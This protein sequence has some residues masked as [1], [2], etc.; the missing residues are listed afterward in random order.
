MLKLVILVLIGCS[1]CMPLSQP[2]T[3]DD[4]TLGILSPSLPSQ[5]PVIKTWHHDCS[6]TSGFEYTEIPTDYHWLDYGWANIQAKLESDGQSLLMPSVPNLPNPSPVPDYYGPVYAYT[7]PDV[8]PLSGLRNLSVQMELNNSDSTYVGFVRVGLFDA[9]DA[10]VLI[11]K[12]Q[13]REYYGTEGWIYW[14]Y[15]LR[16]QTIHRYFLKNEHSND[17]G[18]G[19]SLTQMEFVNATWSS[20]FDP[21]RGLIGSIPPLESLPTANVTFVP[22][23]EVETAH[24]IRYLVLMFGMYYPWRN[25]PLIP[26]RI[27]DIFLE[28]E[29]SGVI[30]TTPPLLTPQLDVLYVV[31][32]TGNVINWRCTDDNPYRYWLFDFEY[33]WF[34]LGHN[35]KEGLWTGSPYTI[36][37]DGLEVGNRTFLLILQDKA[38]FMVW[39]MVTVIVV[40]HPFVAFIITN[41]IIIVI[42]TIIVLGCIFI[43]ME[44]R[45]AALYRKERISL[46]QKQ[47]SSAVTSQY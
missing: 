23:E 35:M 37:V 6:N 19:Y 25:Q 17:Y 10:P 20:R 38:G 21:S 7:L 30:D 5:E 34:S 3:S 15:Y 41:P 9:S 24:D 47:G 1:L 27:H 29:T 28:Y 18:M 43:L 11:S 22:I 4:V 46:Y 12:I 33:P 32:Q 45:K 26:V 13:D 14:D 8:F 44:Q 2:A 42:I 36:S 40:E 31:G 39:D 16:N